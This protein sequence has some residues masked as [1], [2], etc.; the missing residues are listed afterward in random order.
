MELPL[1]TF[2]WINFA[3]LGMSMHVA[4]ATCIFV[5]QFSCT[6]AN[7]RKQPKLSAIRY[8]LTKKS[9]SYVLF[10]DSVCTTDFHVQCTVSGCTANI[11]THTFYIAWHTEKR[12][13]FRE[14]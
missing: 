3:L 5:E 4:L 8:V 2:R 13:L 11:F 9:Y 6:I 14:N 1:K 10:T 12:L 7:P